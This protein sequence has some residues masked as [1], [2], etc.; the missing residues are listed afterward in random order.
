MA[1]LVARTRCRQRSGRARCVEHGPTGGRPVEVGVGHALDAEPGQVGSGDH[2]PMAQQLVG[3]PHLE[4]GAR[5]PTTRRHADGAVDPQHQRP[6]ARGDARRRGHGH[7]RADGAAARI[8][9]AVADP[10][11]DCTGRRGD[12]LA[13]QHLPSRPVTRL[14][15]VVEA[16]PVGSRWGRAPSPAPRRHRPLERTHR[17]TS[18]SARCERR[19][20]YAFRHDDVAPAVAAGGSPD[21]HRPRRAVR[22]PPSPHRSVGARRAPAA[23]LDGVE[24]PAVLHRL[25]GARRALHR[26][27]HRPPRPRPRPALARRLHAWRTPP[28]TP[29]RPHARSAWTG[30]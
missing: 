5:R 17:V 30:S 26:R 7:R 16:G 29:P 19:W 1:T 24:R 13:R 22:P 8:Q 6:W 12:R 23:R 9:R 11:R 2:D 10:P 4:P 15:G 25:R 14:G 20:P 28:T 21:P 3:V 18:V 27:R